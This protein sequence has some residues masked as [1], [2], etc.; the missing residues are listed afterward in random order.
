MSIYMYFVIFKESAVDFQEIEE[1][2]MIVKQRK[3]Q[4][5]QELEFLQKVDDEKHKGFYFKKI[6][7]TCLD[8]LF[9]LKC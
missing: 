2:L 3:T 6:Y 9:V 5:E 7:Y 4:G 1:A 8:T